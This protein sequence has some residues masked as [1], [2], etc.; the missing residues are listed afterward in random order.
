VN[1]GDI[2]RLGEGGGG[3]R[4]KGIPE[5][6][7]GQNRSQTANWALT[8]LRMLSSQPLMIEI[9]GFILLTLDRDRQRNIGVSHAQRSAHMQSL[10]TVQT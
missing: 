7:E 9:F 6:G 10:Q 5:V 3:E 1:S 8:A 4:V 2:L